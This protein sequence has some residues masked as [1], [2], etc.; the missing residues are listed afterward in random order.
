MVVFKCIVGLITTLKKRSE[1]ILSGLP[2]L[3]Q[4]FIYY[5]Y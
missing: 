3:Q 2:C 1:K 4:L 5:Y